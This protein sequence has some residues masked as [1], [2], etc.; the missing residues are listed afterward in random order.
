M[1]ACELCQREVQLDK[2]HLVCKSQ[3]SKKTI[4]RR[5]SKKEMHNKILMVCK[6]CHTNLHSMFDEKTL[7]RELNSKETLLIQPAIQ[8]FIIWVQKQK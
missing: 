1:L 4:Q 3:W 7:A 2:H 8:K 6:L 5:F